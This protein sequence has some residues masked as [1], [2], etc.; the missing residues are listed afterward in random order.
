[1]NFAYYKKQ[2]IAGELARDRMQL[3]DDL[4]LLRR[5]LEIRRHIIQSIRDYPREW[6]TAGLIVEWLLSRLSARK[7]F[8]S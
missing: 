6:L 5:D 1:M 2:Q 7:K 3:H 8:R 4:L